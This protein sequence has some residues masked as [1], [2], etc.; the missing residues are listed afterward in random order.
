MYSHS[1]TCDDVHRRMAF[2]WESHG[3]LSSAPWKI[4][5]SLHHMTAGLVSLWDLAGPCTLLLAGHKICLLWALTNLHPDVPASFHYL[6][7]LICNRMPPTDSLDLSPLHISSL[8]NTPLHFSPIF[9]LDQQKHPFS[10]PHKPLF[11]ALIGSRSGHVRTQ[12]FHSIPQQA[13]ENWGPLFHFPPASYIIRNFQPANCSA[14]HTFHAGILL[15]LFDP[16]DWGDMFP[17]NGWLQR[18]TWRYIPEVSTLQI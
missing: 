15:G 16:E 6:C 11:L 17:R 10:R 7:S 5:G 14:C 12:Q 13:N 2:V 1:Y 4:T 3:N 9:F 8:S 18:T